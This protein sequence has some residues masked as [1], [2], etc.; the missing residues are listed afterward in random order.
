MESSRGKFN[1]WCQ[2]EW[3]LK[4]YSTSERAG[5]ELREEGKGE[6]PTGEVG[7]QGQLNQEKI[8]HDY[9]GVSC[10]NKGGEE[11]GKRV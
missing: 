1:R 11:K 2:G 9:K 6:K 10:M 5:K 4:G 7:N 3:D 8:I